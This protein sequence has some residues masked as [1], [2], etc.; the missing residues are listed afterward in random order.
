MRK[1]LLRFRV[2]MYGSLLCG[3]LVPTLGQS[4][5][6]AF[7][8]AESLRFSQMSQSYNLVDV[9]KE[10]SRSY[11]VIFDYNPKMLKGKSVS[12]D[13]KE[14]QSKDLDQILNEMLTPLKLTFEKNNS[15]SYIIYPKKDKTQAD[16]SGRGSENTGMTDMALINSTALAGPVNSISTPVMAFEIKGQVKDDKGEGLPGVSVS[17]KGT[18][19]GTVTDGTGK[20]AITIPEGTGTLVFSFVGYMT[21]EVPV[22]GRNTIDV[23]LVPDIQSLQEI[24]VT[25]LGVK[26]ERKAVG[27]SITEVQGEEIG[28]AATVNPVNALQGKVAGVQITPGAGGTFGGSRITIRGNSTFRNNNQPI[29]VIDGVIIDNNTSG[30]DEYGVTDWGNDLKNLNPDDF[31]SLSILKGAAATA[32][33]GSRALNGVVLITTKKGTKKK[34]IGVEVSQTL[35]FKRAY[36]GPKFQNIYGY[37]A[38]AFSASASGSTRKDSYNTDQFDLNSD[39]EPKLLTDWGVSSWGPKMTGQ[40]VRGYDNEWTQFSPQPDN[41]TDAYDK[42][43]FSNTNVALNGAGDNVTYRLSYTGTKEKGIEIRNDFVKNGFNGRV[44]Y[45]LNKAIKT[46]VGFNYTS[47]E[48]KNPP[49]RTMQ[50]AFVYDYFPR[51]YNTNQWQQNYRADHGGVPLSDDINQSPGS[52]LWFTLFENSRARKEDVL[53]G[54]MSVN[55]IITDW[56]NVTVEGYFNNIYRKTEVKELGQ[57]INNQGGKY[58]IENARK[59]LNSLQARLNMHKTFFETLDADFSVGTEARRESGSFNR[60]STEGGLIVPGNYN[61]GNSQNLPIAEAGNVT[62]GIIGDRK[63]NSIYSYLNLGY[64]EMLYLQVTARNDWSSTLTYSDGHGNNSYF[65]PSASLSWVFTETFKLPQFFS[66][67]KLR[68][69]YAIVGRDTDPYSLSDGYSRKGTL[70]NAAGNLPMYSY[71]SFTVPNQNL[72]PERQRSIEVGAEMKFF[73]GRVGIDMAYYKNNTFNQIF[74]LGVTPES[75]LENILVNGGNIQSQGIEILLTGTPVKKRDL[76]WDVSA[77]FTRNRDLIKD[78]YP[79]IKERVLEGN[80]TYGDRI[81]S[82]AYIGQAYGD[83]VTDSYYMPYQRLDANGNKVDDPNNGKPVLRWDGANKGAYPLRSGVKQTIGN[84]QSDWY[85]FVSNRV[86]YKGF[87]LSALVDIKM[88]GDIYSFAHRYG[89]AY[90]LFESTLA[91]RDGIKWTADGNEYHDGMIPDGV[92]A[93][94]TVIKDVDVSGMSYK[95]AYDKGLVDPTHYSYYM[96]RKGSWSRGIVEVHENSYVAL[97]EVT[98]GY[99]FPQAFSEKLRLNN[100]SLMF[101]GR[102]L[103]MLYN[104]LPDHINGNANASNRSGAAFEYGTAPYVRSMGFTIKAGF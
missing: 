87:F 46:D 92:F 2:I 36:A 57:G 80:P 68:T 35:N 29:F 85:G 64:R 70:Q 95:D 31:E 89:S 38:P 41:F 71:K 30:G 98:F 9:L 33:Y 97:R 39:G 15:H 84:I 60:S 16:A 100:L 78:M 1:N 13:R 37:G 54:N 52:S 17:L 94:G 79:G 83:L 11:G 73:N 26:R 34:G 47:S 53:R 44:T 66:F 49:N 10:L 99:T 59:Q 8:S 65:Y 77:S 58:E 14:M 45:D 50:R 32:L 7:A 103:G 28:R 6:L 81:A 93:N 25:S 18:T 88:G 82:V 23:T 22:S 67:G 76:T 4:E 5:P 74:S 43:Y 101:V 75:G 72:K 61:I 3:S 51:S 55:G 62:D 104:S 24:V 63:V 102:D 69:S 86:S 90:G 56:L 96:Y 40:Q 19:T 48:S 91:G 27:Y 12:L 21:E 42:G 20:Y